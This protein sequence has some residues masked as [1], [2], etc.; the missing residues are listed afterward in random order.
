MW[1]LYWEY[2][3]MGIILVPGIIFAAVAQAKVSSTYNAFSRIICRKGYTGAQAARIILDAANLQDV[4]IKRIGGQLTDNYDPKRKIVSLSTNV[5]DGQSVAS[6]GIAAHEI[7]HAIQHKQGYWPV[8]VRGFLIPVT[9]FMSV[10]LWPLLIIGIIFNFVAVPGSIVGMVFIWCGIGLFTLS[11]LIEL[12]TLPT[13]Y[14]ASRRATEILEKSGILDA[15][16]TN[17][18]RKVLGAAA[19]TYVGSLL[20]SILSLLR[21][22]LVFVIGRGRD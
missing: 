15:T 20:I 11:I 18:A 22:L 13:E 12:V 7:G 16:E 8:K 10:L 3:L 14:N 9:N 1:S 6:I 4:Q 19:L 21:F 5:H 2:Y 17:G